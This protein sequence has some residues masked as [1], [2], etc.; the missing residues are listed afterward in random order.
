MKLLW[1]S[2]KDKGGDGDVVAHSPKRSKDR[3]KD[4]I[5]IESPR[6]AAGHDDRE[7]RRHGTKRAAS[8]KTKSKPASAKPLIPVRGASVRRH[9]QV[10]FAAGQA[11]PGHKWAE[12]S[13]VERDRL[14]CGLLAS[15]LGF[16]FSSGT[17]YMGRLMH[18]T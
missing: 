7:E 16:Y 8:T 11:R 1:H 13:R 6:V 18:A 10:R 15:L 9:D 17:K 5:A 2:S 14:G 12:K 4:N 3:D